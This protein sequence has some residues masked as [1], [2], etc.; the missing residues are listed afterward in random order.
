MSRLNYFVCELEAYSL[1]ICNSRRLHI[2]TNYMNLTRNL[3]LALGLVVGS[4]SFAQTTTASN[5]NAAHGLLGNRYTELIL[6][7]QDLSDVSEAGFIGGVSA[8]NPVVPGMLD[9][10]ASF[11]YNYVP[12]PTEASEGHANTISGYAVAYF[13]FKRIKPFAGG[14]LGYQWVSFGNGDEQGLWGFIVGV[15]T[16]IRAVTITPKVTYSD[17]FENS[18]EVWTYQ[19]EASYWY[20]ETGAVFGSVGRTDARRNWSDSWNYQVGMRARF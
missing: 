3:T 1:L 11:T 6:G 12:G 17:G 15:E 18:T 2:G 13:P 8:N 5:G 10:G 19:V 4:V 7:L 16:A 14:Q 9:A 20:N